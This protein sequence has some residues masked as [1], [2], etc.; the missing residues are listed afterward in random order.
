VTRY[1]DGLEKFMVPVEER[2]ALVEFIGD[3][4]LELPEEDDPA[5]CYHPNTRSSLARLDALVDN[6]EVGEMSES[7]GK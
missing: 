6:T 1:E 7:A 3:A 2:D 5:H 4:R